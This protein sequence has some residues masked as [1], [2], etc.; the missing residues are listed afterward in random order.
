MEYKKKSFSVSVGSKKYRNGWDRIF[1][2]S[3]DQ[4][5]EQKEEVTGWALEEVIGFVSPDLSIQEL[6]NMLGKCN[7]S[8]CRFVSNKVNDA[9]CGKCKRLCKLIER[10]KAE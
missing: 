10:K 8:G 3:L 1:N 4:E 5:E 9:P 2:Q 7:L 6:K